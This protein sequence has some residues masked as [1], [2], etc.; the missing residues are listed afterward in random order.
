MRIDVVTIFPAFF[1]VLEVSLLGKARGAGILDVA[2]AVFE[3][4]GYDAAT[5]NLVASRAGVPV[6]TLYRWFPDKA[7]LAEALADRYLDRLVALYDELLG[8]PAGP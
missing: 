3:K 6:G 8:V 1:D 2:E 7:A 4:V 5:T